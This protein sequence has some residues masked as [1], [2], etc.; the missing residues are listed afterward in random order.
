LGAG[1]GIWFSIAWL[2]S[3]P[4][5]AANARRIE[6]AGPK[7]TDWTAFALDLIQ[8]KEN[9]GKTTGVRPL[10][11]YPADDGMVLSSPAVAGD[12]VIGSAAIQDVASYFGQLY[13]LD[14]G[15]GKQIWKL[16]QADGEDLKP[17]FSSPTLTADRKAFVIGQGLHDHRD[18]YLLCV[19]IETG[20][21]RWKVKTPLHI[22]S[23]PAVHGDLAVVGAGAIEDASHKPT[24]DPGY[25][26]AVRIS[27]GKELWRHPVND[28]ESSPAIADDGTVFIGSG[29]NGNA[30]VALRSESDDELKA[31]NLKRELWKVAAPYPITG[32]VT[33][34]GDLVIVGGG[35][36][37]FVNAD[38]KPAGIVIA[39]DRKTGAVKWQTP[40][41]DSVLNDIRVTKDKVICPVR[42][43]QV[44]ALALA[45]G[46][47]VWSQAVSGK[48]PILAGV[49]V[50]DDGQ[51][52]FAVSN[53]GYLA[54]L[55]TGDGKILERHP[56]NRKDKPGERGLTL[57]TPTVA[58]GK[59]LLGSET[60]GLRCFEM[61]GGK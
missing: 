16:D 12:K 33:L 42:N 19:E 35:N 58:N 55:N 61:V 46:K 56:V 48:A 17:F 24:S 14:A 3:T 28:P 6:P 5:Q 49:A 57:S 27:D 30:I 23:T 25:V 60:G 9:A 54:L 1:A 29:F 47:P 50:S 38:P 8:K 20:K 37:D 32:P 40:L 21:V 15:T 41:A 2:M 31:K 44:I 36:C 59:V 34:A 43:G 4:A 7:K 22:E 52:V 13:A 45:D 53:D 26:F 51:T 10:W 11:D 18:C 39:L